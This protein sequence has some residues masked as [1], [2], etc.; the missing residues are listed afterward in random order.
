MS[1]FRQ[2]WTLYKVIIYYHVLRLI[3]PFLSL[4]VDFDVKFNTIATFQ[5]LPLLH[6]VTKCASQNVIEV[7]VKEHSLL[8]LRIRKVARTMLSFFITRGRIV[9]EGQR[10]N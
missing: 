1:V 9:G 10:G 6:G 5:Y 7:A 4:I 3:Q 2:I 8:N